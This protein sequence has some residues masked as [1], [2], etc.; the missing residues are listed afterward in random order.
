M[1]S[2]QVTHKTWNTNNVLSIKLQYDKYNKCMILHHKHAPVFGLMI[3]DMIFFSWELKNWR[4]EDSYQIWHWADISNTKL[5]VQR[6][7]RM[8]DLNWNKWELGH[9]WLGL[10][11][12]YARREFSQ[13]PFSHYTVTVNMY[14]YKYIN[15]HIYRNK[16]ICL[17]Y[18]YM[19]KI[20]TYKFI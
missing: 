14:T 17:I 3:W 10:T 16:W 11:G 5:S 12:I 8:N 19:N 4:I 2:Y 1:R 15:V 6:N 13:R 18:L 7:V 9:A 20:N